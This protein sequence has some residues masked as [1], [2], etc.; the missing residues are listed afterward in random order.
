MKCMAELHIGDD[1]GDNQATIRCQLEVGHEGPHQEIFDRDGE[2][3]IT[4]VCNERE[5]LS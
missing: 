2:V 1:Y 5:E 4:F 3:K